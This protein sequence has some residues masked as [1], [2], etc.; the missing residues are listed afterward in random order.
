MEAMPVN[1]FLPDEII[2]LERTLSNEIGKG[3]CATSSSIPNPNL[4][5]Y[6][7]PLYIG[8]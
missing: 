2:M 7:F 4:E 3:G 8:Q 5:T 6:G 1:R